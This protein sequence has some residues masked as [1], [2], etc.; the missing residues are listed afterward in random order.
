MGPAA[1]LRASLGAFAA[2]WREERVGE[3]TSAAHGGVLPTCAMAARPTAGKITP[4]WAGA[5][6]GQDGRPRPGGCHGGPRR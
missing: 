4:F 2:H 5:V 6:T 3:R 1:S